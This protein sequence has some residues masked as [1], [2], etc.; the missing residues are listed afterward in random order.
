[1]LSWTSSEPLRARPPQ[2]SRARKYNLI[3]PRRCAEL[4]CLVPSAAPREQVAYE[5]TESIVDAVYDLQKN[6]N[7]EVDVHALRDEYGADLVQLIGFYANTC[8]IG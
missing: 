2:G 7:F 3:Y 6:E 5:E 8:G 4:P 1:M